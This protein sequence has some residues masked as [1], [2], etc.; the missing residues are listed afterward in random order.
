[1]PAW[2][3]MSETNSEYAGLGGDAC[4]KPQLYALR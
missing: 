4:D 3:G 1:M 2:A